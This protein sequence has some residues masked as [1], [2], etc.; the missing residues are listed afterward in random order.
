MFKWTAFP[1]IRISIFIILGIVIFDHFPLFWLQWKIILPISI[2]AIILTTYFTKIPVL[3][4]FLFLMLLFYIGGVL[5]FLSNDQLSPIHYSKIGQVDGFV[6]KITSDHTERTNYLRYEMKLKGVIHDSAISP[7]SG[8]IF[9]YIKKDSSVEKAYRYG[10][11][12]SISKGYFEVSAPNNPHEFNYREYL[13]KQDIYA[14]AFVGPNDV[15]YLTSHPD[16]YML[17]LAYSIRSGI[18]SQIEQ[19]IRAPREQAIVSALLVGIKDHLDDE[20]KLAYSS[21]GAMHVLAV[22]GLHVGIVFVILSYIFRSWKER[23]VGRFVFA[24][25]SIIIIWMYALVTGFSPSVMRAVTM[26]TVIIVSSAFNRRAN[27]YNSLGIAAFVLVLLKP[28]I[29]YSVGF[30]LSFVA[31]IGIVML[32]PRIYRLWEPKY[33]VLDYVWSITC[34]SIAA[35]IATFP[36]TLLYFH[37]F[38]TYFLVSN[39]V[40][41]PAAAL[42]L[43]TGLLMSLFGVIHAGVGDFIGQLLEWIVFGVNEVIGALQHLP[44]P[45]FDWLYFDP[46]DTLLV[47]LIFLFGFLGLSRFDFKSLA[48][49]GAVLI[50]IFGWNDFKL[51]KQSTHKEIVFYEIEDVTAIDLIQGQEAELLIDDFTAENWEVISFQVDPNRLANGLPKAVESRSLLSQSELVYHDENFDL[52]E[53]NDLRV[54]S[55]H[56]DGKKLKQSP[57]AEVIYFKNPK[58]VTFDIETRLVILGTGFNYYESRDTKSRFE[59]LGIEVHVLSEDGYWSHK[60]NS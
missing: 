23:P 44:K 25:V 27:I 59:K 32:Q 28:Y 36:L 51:L 29:I 21:A 43:V 8:K 15:Y 10:D 11:L 16:N 47:Y 49:S 18:K 33:K 14:H 57:T 53:W 7:V 40:V 13:E 4:G 37:Q 58:D 31:V 60:F 6:G 20:T 54:M 2:V 42:M 22:S 5:A 55:L 30:Q 9:L 56:L 38:P 45:I 1:F 46:L 12:L 50:L 35:Q 19:H 24:L 34:V 52:I 17:S 26:F 3:K 48:V 41:I 39:L